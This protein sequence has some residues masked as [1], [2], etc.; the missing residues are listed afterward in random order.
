MGKGIMTR[1]VSFRLFVGC[2][3]SSDYAGS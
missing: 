1:N 2:I 3:N